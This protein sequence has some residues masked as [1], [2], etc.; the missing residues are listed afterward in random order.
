MSHMKIG[1][2]GSGQVGQRLASGFIKHGHEV[3]IGTR[4]PAKLTDWQAEAGDRAHVGTPAETAG[5]GEVLVLAVPG[6]AAED[7]VRSLGAPA[8]AGKIVIDA[9]NPISER[10]P[11]NGVLGYFT[12]L[13]ES[14]MER[15]QKAVP[16]ARFVKA[17]NSVGNAFMVNPQFPGGTPTS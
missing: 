3:M 11:E 1:V 17:F 6:R 10:A 15:L 9:T 16:E 2:L 13:N 7:V 5:F 4:D 8:M 12:D 14:L